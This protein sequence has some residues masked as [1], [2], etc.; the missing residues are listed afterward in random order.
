M[1][2]RGM[3]PSFRCIIWPGPY[4]IG[5]PPVPIEDLEKAFQYLKDVDDFSIEDERNYVHRVSGD[6]P[7]KEVWAI[8]MKAAGYGPL[9]QK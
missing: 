6:T 8:M 3:V 5:T 9:R 2:L 1:A 4:K 7:I